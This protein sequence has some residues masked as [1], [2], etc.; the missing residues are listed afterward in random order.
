MMLS[1]DS[2]LAITVTRKN[3]RECWIKMYDLETYE[4]SFEEKVG[5]KPDSYI[6]VKEVEQN[7][8]G[9]HYAI[10]YID[11]GNFRLRTFGKK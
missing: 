2:S 4:L 5:G 7:F 11:D 10:V 1:Y 8:A 9:N 3:D 6:K